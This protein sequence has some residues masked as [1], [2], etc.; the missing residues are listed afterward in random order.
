MFVGG[1]TRVLTSSPGI[2]SGMVRRQTFSKTRKKM[3]KENL[4]LK[5]VKEIAAKDKQYQEIVQLIK[6]EKSPSSLPPDHLGKRAAGMF[7]EMSLLDDDD[8]TLII[9]EGVKIFLPEEAAQK[10]CKEI[11]EKCHCAGEKTIHTLRKGY[12]FPGMRKM[13]FNI[14]KE[15]PSCLKNKPLQNKGMETTNPEPITA[16]QPWEMICLDNFSMFGWH[17]LICVDR[18][19]G[20]T[21]VNSIG[22]ETTDNVIEALELWFSANGLPC[23][24]LRDGGSCF[25]SRKMQA[26][27]ESL[28]I[29]HIFSSPE[30]PESNGQA[31]ASVKK[32]KNL[33][34]NMNLTV[35]NISA[36]IQLSL[37]QLNNM[38]S[39][40]DQ[41]SPAEAFFGRTVRTLSTPLLEEKP[42]DRQ[43]AAVIRQMK[44]DK[45]K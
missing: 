5:T 15:C 34:C 38:A 44:H 7:N 2:Q 41:C 37:S 40:K 13:V 35:K 9:V 1:R 12:F 22:R 24:I 45:R 14:C 16:L 8:K 27:T 10:L 19:S 39:G 33:A 28:N 21:L 20:Y 11:H 31:E 29:I 17:H 3:E 4:G 42:I 26:F 23:K 6:T 32:V 36:R 43:E 25:T 18:M 30:N